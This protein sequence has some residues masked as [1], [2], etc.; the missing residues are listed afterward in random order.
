MASGRSISVPCNCSTS[1]GSKP[2]T[3]SPANAAPGSPGVEI[4]S[5]DA[6]LIDYNSQKVIP[7]GSSQPHQNLQPYTCVSFII[8]T[9]GIFPSQG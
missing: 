3:P 5:E 7:S 6:P 4:Y 2:N 9:E 1:S 8:A